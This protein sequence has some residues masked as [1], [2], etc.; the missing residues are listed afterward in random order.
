MSDACF[1]VRNPNV[2]VVP[3]QLRKS[4]GK[5][6]KM[7]RRGLH[8]ED[9]KYSTMDGPP[10]VTRAKV[11]SVKTKRGA[12]H[13][14]M[15]PGSPKKSRPGKENIVRT[16]ARAEPIS[17]TKIHWMRTN[18]PWAM[19]ECGMEEQRMT[20]I[21]QPSKEGDLAIRT[22]CVKKENRSVKRWHHIYGRKSTDRPVRLEG[23]QPNI[24]SG[25]FCK[26][27]SRFAGTKR[28]NQL[29]LTI[30][31]LGEDN[32]D[33]WKQY[34]APTTPSPNQHILSQLTTDEN[35]SRL[36]IH[37][38]KQSKPQPPSPKRILRK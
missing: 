12:F 38:T 4:G 11:K 30:P 28:G 7:L 14:G 36:H 13:G 37:P 6:R 26:I 20:L 29:K 27:L 8:L 21:T 3:H 19:E 15:G 22:T 31:K 24:G 2:F 25:Q 10:Q 1:L 9:K 18:E 17:W 23:D 32:L 5:S 35:V 34:G 33:R 16:L